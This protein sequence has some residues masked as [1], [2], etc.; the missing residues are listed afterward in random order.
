MGATGARQTYSN[1]S[2]ASSA[3]RARECVL[4]LCVSEVFACLSLA[5]PFLVSRLR[6]P[7]AAA[8]PSIIG[9]RT[10]VSLPFAHYCTAAW[11]PFASCFI[12]VPCDWL[13]VSVVQRPAS[14]PHFAA[15]LA[16]LPQSAC[17]HRLRLPAAAAAPPT[18]TITASAL[19]ILSPSN[20]TRPPTHLH[21]ST[22]PASQPYPGLARRL[23]ASHPSHST[24]TLSQ[25]ATGPSLTTPPLLC[26]PSLA[27]YPWR[28]PGLSSSFAWHTAASHSMRSW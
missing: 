23:P 19:P 14:V 4:S 6:I 26:L 7:A 9:A 21:Q 18:S 13:A 24:Q 12:A 17:Y 22:H 2:G 15:R 8:A 11:K 28:S 1:A 27:F 3:L 20:P 10:C 25:L 16:C 5:T